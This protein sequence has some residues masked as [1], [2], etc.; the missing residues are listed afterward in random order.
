MKKLVMLFLFS[1]IPYQLFAQDIDERT[2]DIYFG[3]G[4]LTTKDEANIAKDILEKT[5][6]TIFRGHNTYFK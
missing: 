4:I 3:N 5:I 2:T 6:L 1:L